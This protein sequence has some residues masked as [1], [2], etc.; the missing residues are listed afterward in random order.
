MSEMTN[1]WADPRP[2]S[3]R[4]GYEED[5]G[6]RYCFEHFGF[7]EPGPFYSGSRRCRRAPATADERSGFGA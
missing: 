3:C 4:F 2:A 1:R 5:D 6:A 7:L